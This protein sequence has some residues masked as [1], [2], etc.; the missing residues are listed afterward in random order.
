MSQDQFLDVIDRDI[1]RL[2]EVEGIEPLA[3]KP[4]NSLSH[5]SARF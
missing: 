5:S 2:S 3:T 4:W 1:D